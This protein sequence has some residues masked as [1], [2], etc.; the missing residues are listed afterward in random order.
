MLSLSLSHAFAKSTKSCMLQNTHAYKCL[1][2]RVCVW[3]CVHLL[4]FMLL[5]LSLSRFHTHNGCWLSLVLNLF[6]RSLCACIL[7]VSSRLD[8]DPDP[9]F[10]VVACM[11]V[12]IGISIACAVYVCL[13]VKICMCVC[14]IESDRIEAGAIEISVVLYKWSTCSYTHAHTYTHTLTHRRTTPVCPLWA[15]VSTTYFVYLG[16]IYEFFLWPNFRMC[17]LISVFGWS[18]LHSQGR[19]QRAEH[20]Q[21]CQ[22]LLYC[23]FLFRLQTN[24][25]NN[26]HT[27]SLA[28]IYTDTY[29]RR[30]RGNSLCAEAYNNNNSG[31]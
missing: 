28:R 20:R 24:C 23:S 3:A 29:I 9:H 18:W 13:C 4:R 8:D 2:M 7:A 25:W 5:T 26:T 12:C 27:H 15:S 10:L 6:W 11:C 1:R 22:S 14:W 16:Y 17:V 19:G 21:R 30:L 31:K